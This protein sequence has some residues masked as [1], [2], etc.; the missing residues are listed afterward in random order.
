MEF[1]EYIQNLRTEQ[2]E[3]EIRCAVSLTQGNSQAP[4]SSFRLIF[5]IRLGI[6]NYSS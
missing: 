6:G 1:G 3:M 5:G 4:N 2:T